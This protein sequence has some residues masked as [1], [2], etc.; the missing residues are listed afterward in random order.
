M[1]DAAGT[2]GATGRGSSRP[3]GAV[4]TIWLNMDRPNNLMI[5]D[6]VMLFDEQ[7][8]WERL[9]RVLRCRLVERF[10]VFR[11]R[12]V[13]PSLPLGQPR[14]E[15]DPDFDIERHLHRVRLPDP[16]D[17]A[18]LQRYL[19]QQVSRPFDRRH[20]LWEYHLID[21]YGAGAAVMA[22][23]HHALA[24]GAALM[25]V[26]LSTTDAT[27]DGD[28]APLRAG[29]R[30]TAAD[31]SSGD[32]V[33]GRDPA[34]RDGRPLAAP[35]E[36]LDGLAGLICTAARIA[37]T[38]AASATAAA[39]AAASVASTALHVLEGLPRLAVHPSPLIDA[40]T[41]TQQTGQVA[42]KLLTTSNPPSPL[43]GVPVP[44]KRV[45]WSTPRPLDDVKRAGRPAGATVNDVLLSALAAAIARYVSDRGGEPAD[46]ITMVPVNLRRPGEPLPPDLGNRFALVLLELPSGD[47]PPLER[48]ALAKQRMDQIKQSPEAVLTFGLIQAI[49]R[50]NQEVERVL[51]DF[52]SNKAFGVTTN[53]IGPGGPRWMAGTPLVGVLGWVPG[54]GNQSLGISI[55][56]YNQTLRVGFKAD[57]AVVPDPEKLVQAF[58]E[59]LDDLLDLTGQGH[60]TR[61]HRAPRTATPR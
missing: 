30:A 50:T 48:L 41:L 14:W 10:R 42:G 15:D 12:P 56:T 13:E 27:P 25:E 46:L 7:V 33:D 61:R 36:S 43:T 8:D 6:S 39:A 47:H 44:A 24:D 5:I 2:G 45:I 29:R 38:A 53:V 60:L 59:A 17:A 18:A 57:V 20:P 49:G 37:N 4:D 11:Q 1:T 31:G 3:I 52:F 40:L 22:R 28:L 51:V 21:G 58:D 35:D 55:L 26:L 9:A 19:E 32:P 16:G 54:S 34:V 23:F